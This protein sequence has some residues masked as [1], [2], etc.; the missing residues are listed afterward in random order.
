M[1]KTKH[2]RREFILKN[3]L[4]GLGTIA[5]MN[6]SGTLL[7]PT[8]DIRT[9]ALLG[10][11]PVRTQGWPVWPQWN[12]ATDEESV[13]KVLRSGSW[14]RAGVV[15]E[16]EKKWAETVGAKRCLAV[17]NGTN[18]LIA[19]LNQFDIGAGDE[20]IIGPYSFISTIIC[21][22]QNGAMPVFVDTDPETFQIDADKI[23]A[24]IT[25]RTRA[26]LPAHTLGMPANMEKIM[27]IAKKHN[28]IVI[29]NACLSWLAEIN[30]KKVGTFGNA[31][32]F[33][34][35]TSKNIPIGEGGAIVSDDEKFMDRCYSYHNYGNPYGS[36]VLPEGVNGGT[37]INGTK[38]RITEYQA[39][40]GSAQ[41]KRLEKQTDTRNE[42]AL[43]LKSKIQN[44]PGI[45]PFKLSPNVTRISA[46]QFPFR[47]KAE[48]FQG[49]P[50]AEFIK[51]LRAE[52]VPSS[53]GYV[54]QN[55]KPYLKN[56]FE[57]KNYR[58]MYSKK[59]LDFD[60]F[61]ERNRCPENNLL[62]EEAV[63]ISQN[64]LLGNKSDMDDIAS[65][66]EKIHK[67][68]GELKKAVKK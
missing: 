65:A 64:M 39:A 34:F 19:S 7:S 22:L 48:E 58:R 6:V 14:T 37:V 12:S 9:P 8:S 46:W 25:P 45:V 4:A 63:W 40:I 55:D 36:V 35:Q 32:C 20:V 61:L 47:Y 52:G 26:I 16:F 42:N 67:A 21:I 2:S 30:H 62:C 23:E 31:G 24:K 53:S 54:T 5:A 60:K 44:I 11:T 56:T 43:Y 33:S 51:A 1:A 27:K 49:L 10:G 15:T 29:E 66:I 38:L 59:V 50:R 28:L 57:S 18:A 41:L 17:V 13:I 3:S 68:A